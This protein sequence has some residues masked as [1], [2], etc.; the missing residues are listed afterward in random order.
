MKNKMSA[1]RANFMLAFEKY[2]GSRPEKITRIELLA[3]MGKHKGQIGPSGQE[4]KFPAWMTNSKQYQAD[5][6]SYYLPWDDL[7]AFLKINPSATPSSKIKIRAE[8]ITSEETDEVSTDLD[9]ISVSHDQES[10][11]QDQV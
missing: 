6:G 7:D 10:E 1:T 4:L 8:K 9:L 5:R 3:F 2:N 11:I